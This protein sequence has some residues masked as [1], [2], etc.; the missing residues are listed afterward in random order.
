VETTREVE[1]AFMGGAYRGAISQSNRVW[2]RG[3]C[4]VGDKMEVFKGNV[5]V[6][7]RRV[8]LDFV[9]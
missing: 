5:V 9:G 2:L 3:N 4:D 1:G 7:T 8:E 6:T